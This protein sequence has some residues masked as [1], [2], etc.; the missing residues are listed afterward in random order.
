MGKTGGHHTIYFVTVLFLAAC[1]APEAEERGHATEQE[2]DEVRGPN[3]PEPWT[4][5]DDGMRVTKSAFEER[6]LT[7]PLT[8]DTALIGCTHPELLWVEANGERYG[9]NGM[10][11]I[12]LKL[13]RFDEVWLFDQE[14]AAQSGV[15]E[16]RVM[17][18]DL[19]REARKLCP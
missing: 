8:V 10:G 15:P 3:E 17:P 14:G 6:G 18:T 11:Q 16:L 2:Q 7:W 12:H 4:T 13:P 9:L 5:E 1:S 19:M